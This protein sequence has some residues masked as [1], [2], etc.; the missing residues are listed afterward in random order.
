MPMLTAKQNSDDAPASQEGDAS[1]L[2]RAVVERLGSLLDED[3]DR[4]P[5]R[6]RS[7]SGEAE[8]PAAA[9]RVLAEALAAIAAG[10]EV[11]VVPMDRML[12]TQQ[13][14]DVLEVSRPFLVGLLEKGELPF[15]RVGTHRRVRL[16][17]VLAYR[18]A[19]D[20]KRRETLAELAADAQELGM[21]Y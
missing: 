6:I 1:S 3:G 13:A 10:R 18:D 19:I 20:Q 17:D 11:A 21:G 16:A 12:T 8:L 9:V 5:L 4:H 2:A 14:A 15:R 7:A